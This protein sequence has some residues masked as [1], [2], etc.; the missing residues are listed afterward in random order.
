MSLKLAV[1]TILIATATAAIAGPLEDGRKLYAI[2]EAS[3]QFCPG[4]SFTFTAKTALKGAFGYSPPGSE[5]EFSLMMDEKEKIIQ[6][7]RKAGNRSAVCDFVMN[8]YG[9]GAKIELLAFD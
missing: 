3:E 9:P 4:I 7:Y 1:A 2:G 5:P 6:A 8:E